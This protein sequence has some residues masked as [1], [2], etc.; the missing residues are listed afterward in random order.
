MKIGIVGDP[1][2]DLKPDMD[3]TLLVASAAHARGHEVHYADLR[4]IWRT[5]QGVFGKWARLS[6]S[7]FEGVRPEN[8][9]TAP[10]AMADSEFDVILM[11][12]DP[13]VNERYIAVTHIL[14]GCTVPVVN[15]PSSV[16]RFN[17]KISVLELPGMCPPS[18]VSLNWEV[19]RDFWKASP[20]GV[21]IKPINEFNGHGVVKLAPDHDEQE[22]QKLVR[23]ATKDLSEF[24][25]I[26]HFV[27]DVEFG[28]KRFFL[29]NGDSIG[30]MKRIPPKGD[31]R[32]NIHLGATP[33]QF[34]PSARD[35]EIVA[36]VKEQLS[37]YDMPIACIDVIGDYLT[38]IN[39]TSPSGIPEINRVYGV[40]LHEV[41]C[42][43][44]ES[45]FS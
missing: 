13:P 30:H 10:V 37:G 2:G 40:R 24:C 6:Y 45:E 26:Q 3:T 32:S 36:A 27:K 17:E 12:Q 14:D 34:E 7:E 31:W 22:I 43:W 15:Q 11:R 9:A 20:E 25:I 29:L 41:L 5:E 18:I 44:L 23:M 16:Q 35:L 1:L 33:V 8:C 42:D 19:I 38:E 21:V 28:D 39:V 4:D